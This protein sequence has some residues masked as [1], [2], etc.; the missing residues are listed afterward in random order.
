MKL[1]KAERIYENFYKQHPRATDLILNLYGITKDYVIDLLLS[2]QHNN[3]YRFKK[4]VKYVKTSSLTYF[5]NKTKEESIHLLSSYVNP[6]K[7]S[8]VIRKKLPITP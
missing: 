7:Y 8:R 4:A 1:A 2:D 3:W 5:A 6:K